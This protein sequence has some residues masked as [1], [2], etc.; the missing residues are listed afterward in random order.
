[1]EH[2]KAV[3]LYY[4]FRL[5]FGRYSRSAQRPELLENRRALEFRDKG[6]K[7]LPGRAGRVV[8]IAARSDS[9]WLLVGVG[10]RGR[11]CEAVCA[12][13]RKST[14]YR[15][16]HWRLTVGVVNGWRNGRSIKV[17]SGFRHKNKKKTTLKDDWRAPGSRTLARK[18]NPG[19]REAEKAG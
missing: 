14:V 8:S 10:W 16:K 7:F 12:C 13:T 5:K 18:D 2:W 17:S 3:K 1:M 11:G 15:Y 6:S 9:G 4:Q 19:W